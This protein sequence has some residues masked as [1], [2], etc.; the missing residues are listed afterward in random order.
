MVGDEA[1][2]FI[3]M[4]D[5]NHPIHNGVVCNWEDMNLVWD[6]TFNEKMKIDPKQCKVMFTEP[7][8]YSMK[9]REKMVEVISTIMYA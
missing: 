1:N 9:S 4:L 8:M 5:I 3:S 7:P 6:Y 2:Q